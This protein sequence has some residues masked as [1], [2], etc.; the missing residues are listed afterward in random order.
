MIWGYAIQYYVPYEIV[1][2]YPA[3][4]KKDGG[5]SGCFGL[6]YIS[7][8]VVL[9]IVVFDELIEAIAKFALRGN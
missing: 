1:H 2:L 3:Q 9:D 8:C 7:V 6:D 4:T 5:R